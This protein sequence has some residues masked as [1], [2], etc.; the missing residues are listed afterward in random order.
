MMPTPRALA[1]IE[2]DDD[3]AAD[4]ALAE[5]LPHVDK[6]AHA[7]VL[8]S[9]L[10]RGHVPTLA[11][12]IRGWDG[13]DGDGY[14]VIAA[15][16]GRLAPALRA[17]VD[18]TDSADRATAIRAIVQSKT[19]SLADLLADALR[20]T[21]DETRRL[22]ADGLE[23]LTNSLL[24][25]PRRP[26]E[27]TT[28]ASQ[29]AAERAMME[30]L[31]SAIR[32]WDRH[33]R[34]AVLRAVMKM[35]DRMEPIIRR[36]LDRSRSTLAQDFGAELARQ[37]DP[38]IAGL[39]IRA[40][41]IPKLRTDAAHFISRTRNPATVL[42]YF[43][44]AQ[45]LAD[46]TVERGFALVRDPVWLCGVLDILLDLSE[47]E[48]DDAIRLLSA[49]GCSPAR[50]GRLFQELIGSGDRAICLAAIR[51]LIR[52]PG[53]MATDTLMV[54]AMRS[55][56]AGAQLAL[57]E[58]RRRRHLEAHTTQQPAPASGASEATTRRD[59]MFSEIWQTWTQSQPGSYGGR[60]HAEAIHHHENPGFMRALRA[61]LSSSD[62]LDRVHALGLARG[63]GL[64]DGVEDAIVRMTRDHEAAV[65]EHAVTTAAALK[66]P[67]ARR[68]IVQALSDPNDR[69]QAA[70]IEALDRIG[71]ADIA[72]SLTPKLQSNSPRVRANAIRALLRLEAIDAAES[73]LDMLEHQTPAQRL[74]ALWVV[75]RCQLRSQLR[76]LRDLAERDP[77][78]RV[79]ARAREVADGLERD[80]GAAVVP[81]LRGAA[82]RNAGDLPYPVFPSKL[83]TRT[84]TAPV[85]QRARAAF[86]GA[87]A[88]SETTA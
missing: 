56:G 24:D 11:E 22:A 69:V 25:T 41:A 71:T 54:A 48:L 60:T 6:V 67:V 31:E 58:W 33:R 75:Q 17:L 51:G 26:G 64:I 76:R 77:D 45:L 38:S 81:I 47:S 35:G 79:R 40:L 63:L 55:S 5:A 62:P 34:R 84:A 50:R 27:S 42:A 49:L 18:S 19:Y 82:R 2:R 78:R 72:R 61:K 39:A 1:L 53:T 10:A 16:S 32:Q 12:L 73:L 68:V 3:S 44:N 4:F 46:R 57:R 70:A 52:D 85:D 88:K 83:L 8:D 28:P 20:Q 23:T 7:A 66:G 59:A 43:K 9:L 74:S 15:H 29:H 36:T 21:C 14:R 30:A 65:R 80:S 87:S 86:P 37:D 13:E